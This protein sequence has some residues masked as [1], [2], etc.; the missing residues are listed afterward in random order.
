MQPNW[1]VYFLVE[2]IDAAV[3]RVRAPGGSVMNGPF[4]MGQMGRMAV[5][6]DPHDG[7]F[8]LIEYAQ[9]VD[10]PSGVSARRAI[11]SSGTVPGRG[12]AYHRQ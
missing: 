8:N 9:P 3:E 6:G 11:V 4:P 5:V 2:V 12:D 7:V 1:S 10:V